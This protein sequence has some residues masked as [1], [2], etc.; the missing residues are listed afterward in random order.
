MGKTRI[1]RGERIG[2]T[3]QIRVGCAAVIFSP[4]RSQILLTR[5][6]D[7]GLWCLP[8][9]RLD[10]GET[11]SECI[12]REVREETGL[13]AQV[14]RLIGVYSTP[15]IVVEY[16]DGNRIQ[17][18]AL[19]FEVKTT[20]QPTLSDEVGEVGYFGPEQIQQLELHH[21]HAQRIRDALAGSI[22]PVI[23]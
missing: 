15:D 12:V 22:Q 1:I 11:V 23:G 4:D 18:V 14:V 10:P 19:T 16:A 9:G 3:A 2:K 8:G 7:N 20:G 21:N 13:E 6:R 17:F 5:R